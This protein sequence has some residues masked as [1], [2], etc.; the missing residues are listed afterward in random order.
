VIVLSEYGITPVSTPIHVNRALREAG[1]I[2]VR[3]GR[4]EMLDVP[5]S[6]AF[7]VAD[8]QIAHIYV[9]E[10]GLIDEVR[11]IVCGAAG[12][13]ARARSP[14]AARLR[15]RSYRSG[16]LVALARPM[17]GSPT[18]TGSTTQGA[19]TS[20]AWSRST[21]SPA[22]TRSSCFLDPAIRSPKL[23]VG[24]R[25]ARRALGFRR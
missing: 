4:G 8:H 5:Q 25:L 14:R 12:R 9:A 7:A 3:R 2:G 17:P 20:R 21:A 24:W 15:A 1:L 13:R 11:R 16:E 6:R 18:T 19:R 10:P 23:A 22:T